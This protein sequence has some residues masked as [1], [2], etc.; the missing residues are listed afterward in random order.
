MSEPKVQTF[1]AVYGVGGKRSRPYA[2][3]AETSYDALQQAEMA[4]GKSPHKQ[5]ITLFGEIANIKPPQPEPLAVLS[6]SFTVS[7]DACNESV[8]YWS[9]VRQAHEGAGG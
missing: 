4:Q 1:Y 9:T 7:L 6:V 2:I 5:E 3:C 8:G